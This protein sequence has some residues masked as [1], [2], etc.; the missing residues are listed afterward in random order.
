[1]ACACGPGQVCQ[2]LKPGCWG[3]QDAK[4]PTWNPGIDMTNALTGTDDSETLVD[5]LRRIVKTKDLRVRGRQ[6]VECQPGMLEDAADRIEILE[7]ALEKIAGA[8]AEMVDEPCE[9]CGTPIPHLC[10]KC[11]S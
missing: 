8:A 9:G 11:S 2:P 10:A 5:W 4:F 7:A 6:H 1:M 3:Y